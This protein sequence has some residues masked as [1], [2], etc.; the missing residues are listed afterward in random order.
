MSVQRVWDVDRYFYSI[1]DEVGQFYQLS[2]LV[3]QVPFIYDALFTL[4]S[5]M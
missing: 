3:C 5:E 2:L 4:L 1:S